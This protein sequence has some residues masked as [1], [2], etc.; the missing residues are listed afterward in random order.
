MTTFLKLGQ[1]GKKSVL[2]LKYEQ[3]LQHY[4]CVVYMRSLLSDC[5]GG[6]PG[7]DGIRHRVKSTRIGTPEVRTFKKINTLPKAEI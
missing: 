5:S 7:E 1:V 3:R 4:C 6:L 2:I